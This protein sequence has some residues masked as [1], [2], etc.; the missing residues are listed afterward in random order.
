MLKKQKFLDK[1]KIKK[2]IYARE[3]GFSSTSQIYIAESL[4]KDNNYLSFLARDLVRKK[5]LFRTWHASGKIFIKISE[6][7]KP[8]NITTASEL[9]ISFLSQDGRE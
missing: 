5:I 4:T 3:L 1:R 7:S 8:K 6:N 9:E 2:S